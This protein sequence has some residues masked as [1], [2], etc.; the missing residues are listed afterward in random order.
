MSYETFLNTSIKSFKSEE[1]KYLCLLYLKNGLFE[2]TFRLCKK[3]HT[4]YFTTNQ[5]SR[6]YLNLN[7][8][9]TV[10]H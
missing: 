2:R 4:V 8:Q 1:P 7:F 10:N 3:T 5:F 6:Y 9:F